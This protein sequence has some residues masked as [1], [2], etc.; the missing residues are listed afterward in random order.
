MWSEIEALKDVIFISLH[1]TPPRQQQ[2]I[3]LKSTASSSSSLI[4]SGFINPN[5]PQPIR[6]ASTESI[7]SMTTTKLNEKFAKKTKTEMRRRGS[8]YFVDDDKFTNKIDDK[9]DNECSSSCSSI[10]FAAM[11]EG[12]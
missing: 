5:V 6:K 2:L 9:K 4:G 1:E 12:I 8:R 11:S 7:K 3:E 10:D